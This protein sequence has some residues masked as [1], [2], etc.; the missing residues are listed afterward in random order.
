VVYALSYGTVQRPPST[1]EGIR[2]L[3]ANNTAAA[4]ARRSI[5]MFSSEAHHYSWYHCK[6]STMPQTRHQLLL[7]LAF[8][9]MSP[10]RAFAPLVVRSVQANLA[11]RQQQTRLFVKSAEKSTKKKGSSNTGGLRRLPVVKA[12]DELMNRAKKVAFQTGAD[13]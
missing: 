3:R 1:V 10:I 2:A 5:V 13:R 8:F 6:H 11:S 7:L 9:F 4:T 12:P